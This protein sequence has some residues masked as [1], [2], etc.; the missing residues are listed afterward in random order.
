MEEKDIRVKLFGYFV[1]RK[2]WYPG[3]DLNP[4]QMA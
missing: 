2:N 1:K 4:Q 3:R